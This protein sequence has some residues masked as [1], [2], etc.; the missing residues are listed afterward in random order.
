[1]FWIREEDRIVIE[2]FN[3]VVIDG[4]LYDDP[5]DLYHPDMNWQPVRNLVIPS[6]GDYYFEG[7]VYPK[8]AFASVFD[9]EKYEWL[10]DLE[11]VKAGR[12]SE[13]DA[14][15]SL[16]IASHGF[17]FGGER[18]SMSDKAQAN[19]H[20]MNGA[21]HTA[22]YMV[23]KGLMTQQMFDAYFPVAA[24]TIDDKTYKL[25]DTATVFA[26]Y[27]TFMQYQSNPSEALASGRDLRTRVMA[28]TTIEELEAI[29]DDRE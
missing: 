7:N 22:L 9:T 12:I 14:K 13:I 5:K 19:W 16:L 29:V 18:F 25:P 28:A 11:K 26:F 27:M 24:S 3:G 17:E 10:I 1:M 6:A 23:A 8:P 21:L 4:K 15:T 2:V 20:G